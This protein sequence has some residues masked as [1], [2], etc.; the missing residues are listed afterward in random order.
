M[1]RAA[2]HGSRGAALAL[3]ALTLAG[4]CRA[5]EAAPAAGRAGAAPPAADAAVQGRSESAAEALDETRYLLTMD[6]LR[7]YYQVQGAIAA[8]SRDAGT[9]ERSA[10]AQSAAAQS[11][12]SGMNAA[13]ERAGLSMEE[14]SIIGLVVT[15]AGG[16]VMDAQASGLDDATAARQANVDPR[17]L[18]FLREHQTEIAQ[19]SR[20]LQAKA[21]R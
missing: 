5:K 13:L 8:A 9:A 4:A 20:E 6:R 10:L 11:M 2:S 15:Q 16:A 21:A 3:L 1:R 12:V 7:K 19:L 14:Y 18:A 17:N